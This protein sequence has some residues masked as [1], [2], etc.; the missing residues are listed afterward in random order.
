MLGGNILM[1]NIFRVAGFGL[2]AA[3]FMAVS[4]TSTFAQNPC[5]DALEVKQVNYT[6]FRDGRKET[7]SKT[8]SIPKAKAGI[9]GGEDWLA[10]YGA[11]P[12]DKAVADFITAKLPELRAWV[13][14]KEMYDAFN[15]AVKDP[16]TVNPGV[17]FSSG[18][19]IIGKDPDSSL[20]VAI[21][22]ATIGYD[23]AVKNPPVNTYD[24][25]AITFAKSA[26]QQI[27]GGKTSNSYGAYKYSFIIK[28]AKGNVDPVKSK[29]NAL[30]YMN[31]TIATIMYYGQKNQKDALAYFYKASQST[32]DTKNKPGVYQA[33]GAW[34]LDEL[35]KINKEREAK[36]AA[37][38]NKD[39]D[40]T[41]AMLGLVKGYADRA[42]D[43]YARASKLAESGTD[44]AYKKS[45]NDK[46]QALYK[47]RFDKTDGIAAYVST[48][49]SKPMPNPATPVEPIK[50]DT[51][52]TTPTTTSST[53]TTNPSTT[54]T[55]KPATTPTNTT[56]KPTDS[57]TKPAT[58]TTKPT[59]TVKPT[60]TTKP[61]TSKT[62]TKTTTKK[63]G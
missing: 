18:K 59:T 11:C 33:I 21:V 6:I 29:E 52:A 62:S 14:R 34:Y 7:A 50:E 55:T 37:N 51:P 45:L 61:S 16:A 22:L 19:Q 60:T 23:N 10:K 57:T 9:K 26:I 28:D 25:D 46:L 41:L 42:I 30:A 36:I 48:V 3:A 20:D 56:T 31:Y 53:T 2:V 38:E 17:A 63:K 12:D 35:L 32:A 8:P 15:N 24:N 5:D 44:A 58:D 54:S 43:A 1:K 40:E 39:N 4:A 27:E 49:M 13:E 47:I